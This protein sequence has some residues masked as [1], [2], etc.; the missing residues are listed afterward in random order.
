MEEKS[1]SSHTVELFSENRLTPGA[2][3]SL[4]DCALSEDSYSFLIQTV[5]TLKIID[6]FHV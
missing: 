6:I 1:P 2:L 3:T 4:V 5:I